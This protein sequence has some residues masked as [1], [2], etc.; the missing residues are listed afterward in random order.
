MQRRSSVP[1]VSRKQ[2]L[3]VLVLVA[4]TLSCSRA[5]E[6]HSVTL[7]WQ[8]SSATAAGYNVYRRTDK[9]TSAYVKIASL[10]AEPRFEDHAVPN[11]ATYVYAV[12]AVD[13]RGRESRFSNVAKVEVR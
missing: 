6:Q 8:A 10:V 4:S 5:S 13:Q 12:T 11:G 1:S 3:I 7:S 2:W 9:P